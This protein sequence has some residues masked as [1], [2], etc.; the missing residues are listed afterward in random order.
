MN[1]E[2]IQNGVQYQNSY[3]LYRE[4]TDNGKIPALLMES[5][6]LNIAYGKQSIVAANPALKISGKNEEFCIEALTEQ[7]EELLK[8]FSKEDFSFA[9]SYT[10]DKRTIR[11]TYKREHN[12]DLTEENRLKQTNA[13]TFLKSVMKKFESEN[14]YAGLYG[15]F[16][17][18]FVR[19]FEFIGNTHSSEPGDDFSLFLPTD[20]YVFDE[21]ARSGVHHE[22]K[23]DGSKIQFE[24]SIPE[25]S[26]IT[27][28]DDMIAASGESMS[29]EEYLRKVDSL[30]RD[31]RN[32]RF[33][34]TVL[35]RS[36][37][38][39][40]IEK[41]LETYGRLNGEIKSPYANPSPYCF[42]FN[43][44]CGEFLYGSSPEI[45]AVVEKTKEG[46]KLT[47]RPLAGTRRRSPN[48]LE[49]AYIRI[50]LLTDPK[51]ISEHLMLVDLARN[52]VFRLCNPFSVKETD[53]LN[54]ESYPNL[55]HIAS[56]IEGILRD[57]I[58]PIEVMLTTLPA[59]TLSGAPKLEAMKAIEELETERRGFYGGA[60]GYITFNGECNT[61]ITIRSVH[62]NDGF[63]KVQAGAGI[64]ADSI[65]EKE[66]DETE[67][68][69]AKPKGNL[70]YPLE[71]RL[72]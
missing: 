16:A 64:V 61:G 22:I 42:F 68:K 60:V 5:K 15:A 6:T 4:L 30:V 24:N 62:V 3:E 39:P 40:L 19:N 2:I 27:S 59:G 49:D 56:G 47:I 11:G 51:E 23:V 10:Q 25:I 52:D 21:L 55:Y 48:P 26:S 57:G 12:L 8:H 71:A 72:R 32:G 31:V 34:Q 66:Y 53:L 7:G 44:G 20:I 70:L 33:M 38:F 36:K 41:P 9:T 45:H 43:L 1:L 35:S 18:D 14:E 46:D 67:T 29:R 54:T 63:S 37:T 13:G 58:T 69:M 50:G 17:Y 28:I 65:P